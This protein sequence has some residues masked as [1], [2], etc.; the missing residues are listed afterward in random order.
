MCRVLKVSPS[1]YYEWLDRP[2]S[3]R[4]IDDAVLVERIRKVHLESDGT[5]GRPRV[6]AELIDQGVRVSSKRLPG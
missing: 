2:P 6:R 4:S 1:G 5:Y 3:R